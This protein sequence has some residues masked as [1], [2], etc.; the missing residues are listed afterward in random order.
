MATFSFDEGML[1]VTLS[2][3]CALRMRVSISAMGSLML[4]LVL[5]PAGLG[6][7]GHFA[8][9]GHFTQFVAGQA[10]LAE[11]A[12]RAAGDHATIALARGVRVARQLLQLQASLVTLFVGLR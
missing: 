11:H 12:A 8:L 7:A 4:I 5:L 9:H 2:T 1:T 6:H 3:C 10:E